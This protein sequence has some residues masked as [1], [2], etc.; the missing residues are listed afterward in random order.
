[1]V[2][3]SS[4]LLKM[5]GPKKKIMR[6][7]AFYY[8]FLQ[9]SWK[10]MISATTFTPIC[11]VR[12]GCCYTVWRQWAT[13]D[14]VPRVFKLCKLLFVHAYLNVKGTGVQKLPSSCS[15]WKFHFLSRTVFNSSIPN[16]AAKL[17]FFHAFYLWVR[18]QISFP[19]P[20]ILLRFMMFFLSYSR[21][22]T[23]FFTCFAIH[24][25]LLILPFECELLTEKT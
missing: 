22:I 23:F 6:A 5:H 14:H 4:S 25:S 1:M 17:G 18:F 19:T 13:P 12:T 15:N 9:Q 16:V 11:S 8:H 3:F 24:Y 7:S 20:A 21:I 2:Y 10:S